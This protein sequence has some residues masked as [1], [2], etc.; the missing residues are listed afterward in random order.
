M[1]NVEDEQVMSSLFEVS[2]TTKTVAPCITENEVL[3]FKL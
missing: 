1:V 3:R 2:K